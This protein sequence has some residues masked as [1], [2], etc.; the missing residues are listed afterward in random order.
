L[1][2]K[3]SA[4]HRFNAKRE[5]RIK[6]DGLKDLKLF[7]RPETGS[8]ALET[9]DM[10]TSGTPHLIWFTERSLTAPASY[11]RKRK[12]LGESRALEKAIWL[13]TSLKGTELLLTVA[14]EARHIWEWKHRIL[15]RLEA[16]N[17]RED[18]RH[19]ER[20]ADNWSREFL[21]RQYKKQA[22][23]EAP[24]AWVPVREEAP[25]DTPARL[26]KDLNDALATLRI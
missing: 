22:W 12:M 1:T 19:A 16:A 18:Y 3:H 15:A 21:A 2:I 5:R 11:A 4:V 25:E 10:R 20:D 14:H 13:H 23:D 17:S 7:S 26:L 9:A 24:R 6:L 8:I